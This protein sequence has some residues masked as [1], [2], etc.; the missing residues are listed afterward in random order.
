MLQRQSEQRHPFTA[1][2][3]LLAIAF[4]SM[5]VFTAI[6]ELMGFLIYKANIIQAIQNGT[7]NSAMLRLFS[8]FYS[9]GTFVIPP[10]IYARLRSREPL[11][12]LDFKSP[13]L[14]LLLIIVIMLAA[15][16]F[17]EWSIQLNQQMKFPAFAASVENW[18]KYKEI[19]AEILT[20]QIL[21]MDSLGG[22][23][24]NLLVVAIIPALG[25]EL[26]FR[27]CLQKIFTNWSNSHHYGIWIAAILFSAIHLQF[28]GFIPRMLLGALFGY[29]FFFSKNIWVPVFAHFLNNASAL[30]AAYILQKQGQSLDNILKPVSQQWYLVILSV[31]FTALLFYIFIEMT[32]K[33]KIV[34]DER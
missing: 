3:L 22:L 26:L 28:Y 33:H 4:G 2:I 1:L 5:V 23:I 17:L 24:I 25:E 10:F 16:P 32:S 31:I 29:L 34:P 7:A 30:I 11:E 27:G 14:I 8:A 6:A 21:K 13:G 12:Y 20:K 18:M 9:V 15:T 19:Q